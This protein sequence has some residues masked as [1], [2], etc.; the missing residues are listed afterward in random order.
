MTT[1]ATAWFY[2]EPE[3]NAYA[4]QERI[5]THFWD[6][7]VGDIFLDTVRAEP[8]FEMQGEYN[9]TPV[10]M[11]WVPKKYMK[12]RLHAGSEALARILSRMLKLK[13]Y[14]KYQDAEGRTI[15]EWYLNDDEGHK[16]WQSVQGLPAY[17]HPERLNGR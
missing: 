6:E 3:H 7:R 15:W 8:P 10:H 2:R 1:T 9:R 5:R 16:R 11:E 14:L 13:P 4:L 12:L 17:R